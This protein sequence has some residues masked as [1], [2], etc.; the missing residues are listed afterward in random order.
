MTEDELADA[1][2]RFGTMVLRRCGRILRDEAEAE[3]ALQAVFMRVWKYGAAYTE[4]E[5]KLLWLYRVA[6]RCCFDL[7]ARRRRLAPEPGPA[8]EAHSA[9]EAERVDDGD[10]LA[11]L[12]GTVD[13][14]MRRIAVLYYVDEMSQ[15]QIAAETGWSR[16][17]INK[18]L[19]SLRAQLSAARARLFGETS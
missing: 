14:R 8:A 7:L 3:D 11:K 4:A 16:Q 17:T 9:G 2:R 15:E 1:Y 13:D 10:L 12:L 19:G 6:D 5:S 18:R